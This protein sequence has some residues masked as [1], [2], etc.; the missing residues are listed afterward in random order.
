MADWQ[1][2]LTGAKET[3]S[4][5]AY[6]VQFQETRKLN[7]YGETDVTLIAP[8]GAVLECGSFALWTLGDLDNAIGKPALDVR[9][10][11]VE[12]ITTNDVGGMHVEYPNATFQVA[13]QF[14]MLEMTGPNATPED[15]IG[16][17]QYDRTQGPSCAMA[18]GAGAVYRNYFV[19]EGL[20]SRSKGQ[21]R[22]DQINSLG[23]VAELL[24]GNYGNRLWEFQNGYVFPTPSGVKILAEKLGDVASREYA[25]CKRALYVGVQ[26][27]TAVTKNPRIRVNQ[28]YCAALPIGYMKYASLRDDSEPFA[29]FILEATYEATLAAAVRCWQRT[30]CS[31]VFLTYVGGGAFKNK[32][33][34]IVH[35]ILN[36][37]RKYQGWPLRVRL[38]NF[39]TISP[40]GTAVVNQWNVENV[41][42][43][44][45]A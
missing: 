28:V 37:L 35:A 39:K 9:A 20:H 12:N 18:A 13:S 45:S 14:N 17:Y 19:V 31:D 15:G 26:A 32:E 38:V 24:G 5:S 7:E 36:A 22:V 11:T 34:W 29:R 43:I 10:I 33:G 23:Y 16:K 4:I 1:E 40:I 41:R 6:Q 2:Q 21:T 25:V 42:E 30:G 44:R 8:N 27:N 3:F